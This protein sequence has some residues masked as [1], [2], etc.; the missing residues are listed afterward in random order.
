V[1]VHSGLEGVMHNGVGAHQDL[2]RWLII[3]L[4]HQ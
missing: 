2:H 4:S 3:G 1:P